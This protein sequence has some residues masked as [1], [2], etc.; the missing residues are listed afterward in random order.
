MWWTFRASFFYFAKIISQKKSFMRKKEASK[1]KFRTF[2][3]R[4]EKKVTQLP[5]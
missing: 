5:S 4:L 3:K 1:Q 2:S